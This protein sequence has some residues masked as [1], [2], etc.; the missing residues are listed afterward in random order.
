VQYIKR[1]HGMMVTTTLVV[2]MF[3]TLFSGSFL[4]IVMPWLIAP[5]PAATSAA[6]PSSATKKSAT[7]P[8]NETRRGHSVN[9]LAYMPG[10]CAQGWQ[11]NGRDLSRNPSAAYTSFAATTPCYGANR[12]LTNG[13][14]NTDY[15]PGSSILEI[16]DFNNSVSSVDIDHECN[17][18]SMH[19]ESVTAG[20]MAALGKR[21]YVLWIRFDERVMKRLFG[22]SKP[23]S[24]RKYML[25]E[26]RDMSAFSI[27][28]ERSGKEIS[29]IVANS[30]KRLGNGDD[31]FSR[32]LQADFD[33]D[34]NSDDEFD[35]EMRMS[36]P[37]LPLSG[38]PTY[39]SSSSWGPPPG[40]MH[41]P[42]PDENTGLLLHGYDEQNV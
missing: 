12:S 1:Q 15:S 39:G 21:L 29:L 35:M 6:V 22:G 10:L 41:T 9:S 31:I 38:L 18:P 17:D 42:P 7:I 16:S 28:S 32:S 11:P 3:T 20:S 30:E 36:S 2:V 40:S 37:V 33:F 34:M 25:E 24:S 26:T 27:L 14:R 4:P 19:E 13:T 23:N 8:E 5:A